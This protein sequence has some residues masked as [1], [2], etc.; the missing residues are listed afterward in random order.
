MRAAHT[1][2]ARP[3]AD[4]MLAALA[5]LGP[6]SV[7]TYMPSFPEIQRTFGVTSLDMQLTVSAYLSTFAIML[8]FHGAISDSFGR[9]PVVLVN[10]LLY[11][12]ATI[13]C[14]M[15]QDL[16]YLLIFRA[17]QGLSA[18]A[19]I[20]IGR[21]MIS[22]SFTG[23]EAQ[24]RM[25]M[26][27]MLFGLA[28]AV[29]PIIGGWLQTSFGWR[30]VFVF[31]VLYAAAVFTYCYLRLP[32]TL[33]RAA[34]QPF[35]LPSLARNY[36]KLLCSPRFGLLSSGNAF[37][38]AG[39]F[40][41][42]S[43]APAIIYKLLHLNENQFAWLFLPTIGGIMLGAFLSGRLAGRL[44][45][46]HTIHIGY[47]VMIV[48]MASSIAYHARFPPALPWTVLPIMIY[49]VGL[50]LTM[51]NMTLFA[52]GLFPNNRGLAASLQAFQQGMFNALV[53]SA[54]SP[55]VSGSGLS[56]AIT[57]FVLLAA[58]AV[59]TFA[60]FRLPDLRERPA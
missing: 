16:K 57:S 56:L 59:C 20:A 48:A 45:P 33:P 17:L 49:S 47:I 43:S 29:G 25:A 35:G 18:G 14:A 12:A 40:L 24:R 4:M 28:P 36:L 37:N 5:M 27:T 11:V 32:E 50:A 55:Y 53:A 46:R 60:Y 38:V 3:P 58:G 1:S 9:R 7:V 44:T 54:L 39:H 51:P 19:G 41:F 34:R 2:H 23:H 6:F 26:V 13:G 22:E 52:I 15:T 42:I 10:L 31:L 21:A 8:L 30:S